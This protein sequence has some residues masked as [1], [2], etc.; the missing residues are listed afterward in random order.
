MLYS[1][2]PLKDSF[3]MKMSMNTAKKQ[4]RTIN[5]GVMPP[6]SVLYPKFCRIVH[7]VIHQILYILKA[8]FWQSTK[9][10]ATLWWIV[11]CIVC[12]EIELSHDGEIVGLHIFSNG[13]ACEQHECCGRAV[14]LGDLLWLKLGVVQLQD[15]SI[16]TIVKAALIK[17]GTETCRVGF[18]PWHVAA[19]ERK[20]G[21]LVGKFSQIIEL[22]DQGDLL[23]KIWKALGTKG[24]R[25][26]VC[27][28]TFLIRSRSF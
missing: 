16:E 28:M 8:Y 26:T 20:R 2:L 5:L 25:A 11:E 19:S 3:F 6:L 4:V 24:W 14:R 22:Y 10:A 23:Q 13:R 21:L 17:D 18:V 27:S 15:S 9:L 7:L 1:F 12:F